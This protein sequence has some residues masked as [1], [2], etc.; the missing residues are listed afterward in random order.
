MID[1]EDG[2]HVLDL[3]RPGIDAKQPAS[4][5]TNAELRAPGPQSHGRARRRLLH[6]L[7]R[8]RPVGRPDLGTVLQN[9]RKR[10][11][12]QRNRWWQWSPQ[13]EQREPERNDRRRTQRSKPNRPPPPG[14]VKQTSQPFAEGLTLL[15]LGQRAF[16]HRVIQRIVLE[17]RQRQ[18]NRRVVEGFIVLPGSD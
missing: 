5:V 16:D 17:A 14:Q 2:S 6:D 7:D 15:E 11:R 12:H 1:T 8:R 10:R 3:N 13:V 9:E 4:V 18:F